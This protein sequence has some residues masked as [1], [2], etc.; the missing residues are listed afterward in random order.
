MIMVMVLVM[1]MVMV[2]VIVL[3]MVMVIVM[4]MVMVMLGADRNM[5]LKH[6]SLCFVI[7]M[8]YET[9]QMTISVNIKFIFHSLVQLPASLKDVAKNVGHSHKCRSQRLLGGHPPSWHGDGC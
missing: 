1:V 7:I 6:S 2:M 4:V 5:A 8:Q 9:S 3:V